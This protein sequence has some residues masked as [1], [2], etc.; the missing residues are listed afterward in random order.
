[1]QVTIKFGPGN[2]VTTEKFVSGSTVGDLSADDS[3]R[4]ALGYGDDVQF[5][6]HGQDMPEHVQLQNGDVVTVVQA[7]GK[8]GS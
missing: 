3:I 8:K 5:H 7:P 2:S 4:S 6:M 1:M